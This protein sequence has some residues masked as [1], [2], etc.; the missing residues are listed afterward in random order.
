MC[1]GRTKSRNRG[2]RAHSYRGYN[3]SEASV[4]YRSSL[5][6]MSVDGTIPAALQ[7]RMLVLQRRALKVERE[8]SPES[9]YD[10]T[11]VRA[12]NKELGRSGS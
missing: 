6:G 5:K 3:E 11:M 8:V 7:N 2:R 10:F 4:V 1:A 9:V 12:I